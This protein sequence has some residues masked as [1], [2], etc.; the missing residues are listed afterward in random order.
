LFI[1]G[2]STYSLVEILWRGYT[3]WT[4]MIT[5]G[6]CFLI[7]FR[8]FD[9][10]EYAKLWKKCL[11]GAGIITGV[12]FLVGCIVN[13]WLHMQ[14]WDYSYLP[15]NVMGQICFLYSILWGLLSIP[16]VYLSNKI[17]KKLF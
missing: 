1:I 17:K 5:G 10:I 9:K 6:I 14:V 2:S 16:A 13:L 3:H 7:L 8:V 15:L 12:E 11:A 4:M